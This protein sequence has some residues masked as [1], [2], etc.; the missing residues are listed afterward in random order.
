MCSACVSLGARDGC[1]AT[2]RRMHAITTRSCCDVLVA[3]SA[4][5]NITHPA[6]TRHQRL[7]HWHDVAG[8]YTRNA[9]ILFL[10]LDN[11]GKTTLLHVLKNDKVGMHQPTHHPGAFHACHRM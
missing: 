2:C 1:T 3:H 4:A 6:S 9:K 10:G 5:L 11:A 7:S 8:L